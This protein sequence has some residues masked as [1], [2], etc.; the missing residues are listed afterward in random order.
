MFTLIIP[1][2]TKVDIHSFQTTNNSCAHYILF[3]SAR[4][5]FDLPL[6]SFLPAQAQHRP[7]IPQGLIDTDRF[8]PSSAI[9]KKLCTLLLNFNL[10]CRIFY[11]VPRIS[12]SGRPKNQNSITFI[13]NYQCSR[14]GKSLKSHIF[15]NANKYILECLA[16]VDTLALSAM[17]RGVIRIG[18]KSLI[19]NVLRHASFPQHEAVQLKSFPGTHAPLLGCPAD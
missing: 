19:V 11:E 8:Y 13:P 7:L 3:L 5:F 17:E 2:N 14:Q 15:F 10:P 1:C 16:L 9:P 12:S 18:S 4:D 6:P